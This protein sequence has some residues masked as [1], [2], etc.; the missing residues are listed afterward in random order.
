VSK[1]KL[2]GAKAK[3]KSFESKLRINKYHYLLILFFVILSVPVFVFSS[4]TQTNTA[5]NA[6][7]NTLGATTT[8]S[9]RLFPDDDNVP[10]E[11]TPNVSVSTAT[12]IYQNNA[13][14]VD[15]LPSTSTAT[16]NKPNIVVIM[17]DDI[18]PIDGRFWTRTT[19]PH[20][21]A[22][23]V[24]KGIKFSNF[25][26][27]TPL[28][29]PG[30]VGFL[31]GQHS[32]NHGVLTNDGTLFKPS[33]T[34]ATEL[35]N[36]GYHTML[37]GKYLNNYRAIP[38]GKAVPP[39]WNKYDAIY[40]ANGKYYDYDIID[41]NGHLTHYGTDPQDY[42][43]DVIADY[44]VREIKNAP[45]DKPLF[46]YYAPYAIHGTGHD[47]SS[48]LIQQTK[49]AARDLGDS[50]CANIGSW[51]P[52][53]FNEGDVSD[54]PDYLASL[55]LLPM[56]AYPL[57]KP[58]ESLLSVDDAVGRIAKALNNEGR[59]NNTVF[60]LM[61][62][63]GMGWGQH[64]WE[65]KGTSFA[66]KIPVYIAWP[67]ARGTAK[68]NSNASLSMI[69]FAPTLCEI[70][71]CTMGPYPN[72]Q[73]KPDGKSFANVLKNQQQGWSRDSWFEMGI[74]G[75]NHWW[76][77]RT[78]PGNPL[79][80]WHYVEYSDGEK[81]LYNTPGSCDGWNSSMAG[82]PCELH[83]LVAK[84]RTQSAAVKNVVSKLHARMQAYKKE[85]GYTPYVYQ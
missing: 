31:T 20:I 58:C 12:S 32:T 21:Y 64:R 52:A 16:T 56:S 30:R 26:G 33:E 51:K 24:S 17:I 66:T 13:N 22:N 25:Y 34:I 50:R 71:G 2:S 76:G 77:V 70:A 84:G 14:T 45:P 68:A 44:T 62:D 73:Q 79:G 39:G 3:Y 48:N 74:I 72:G 29:C 81:E 67:A 53:N 7:E 69:D 55:P 38:V 23:I 85:K 27:E 43:T 61:G 10:N 35:L 5:I 40:E 47:T 37:A 42:S 1:D 18:N 65:S 36:V 80:A 41:K 82:D 59:L 9:N 15:A 46:V 11:T 4:H 8:I 54:K 6:K 83:N 78:A 75:G 49:P 60:I 57:K 63:N 28:C 19:T